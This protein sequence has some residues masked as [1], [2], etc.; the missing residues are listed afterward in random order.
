MEKKK[1]E[2]Y[3]HIPFCK[4]KCLYC[5]FLSAPT[6]DMTRKKY[7]QTLIEEIKEKA[8]EYQNYSIPTVFF[9]GGTPSLLPGS[10]IAEI[11]EAVN[12][13]FSVEKNAE[14]TIECNPG[15]LNRE[16]TAHYKKAGIN[17]ISL[18]LQS[19]H[20]EELQML[21]RIHSFEDFLRSYDLIR[22]EGFDNVN[23]DLMFALPFQQLKQWETTLKK[24]SSLQP[25][26]ISAYSLI[27]EETTPF[28]EKFSKEEQRRLDGEETTILP[29]EE[30]ERTMYERTSE[31]LNMYG[32]EQYEISNYA[33]RGKQ[34][35]HNLGYWKRENYLGFGLG[36][37]SL[38]ENQRFCNTSNLQEY[39]LG[40]WKKYQIEEITRKA[41]MEETMF[42]GLRLLEGIQR[43]EFQKTFGI[44]LE[45]IYGTEIRR[46]CDL[47]LLQ[48]SQGGVFLTREGLSLSNYVMAEFLKES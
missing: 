31:I 13:S 14:I 24:V 46:L 29:S 16:K 7:V 38:V 26:H 10:F 42:L 47:G 44:Q 20:Q 27:I 4:Q 33:K 43:S 45:S 35:K 30:L 23:V 15:T 21:G 39:L 41:Q 36:S 18:G 17:R 12:A 3:L 40:D 11:M 1:I 5:D 8:T 25:E 2:L 37:A 32:Y 34:C 19:V 28:Y 6:D 22:K 9:G 48:Q